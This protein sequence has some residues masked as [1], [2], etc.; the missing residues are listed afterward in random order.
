M[1]IHLIQYNISSKKNMNSKWKSLEVQS[2]RFSMISKFMAIFSAYPL[3]MRSI[4][5]KSNFF[6]VRI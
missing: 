2:I 6:W 3:K 4:S 5:I 1:L